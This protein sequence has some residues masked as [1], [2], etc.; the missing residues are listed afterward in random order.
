MW[1]I[2]GSV[3]VHGVA[4]LVGLHAAAAGPLPAGSAP[5]SAAQLAAENVLPIDVAPIVAAEPPAEPPLAGAE[6]TPLPVAPL[7]LARTS[8][9][10]SAPA[11]PAA[12]P[13][14]IATGPA[15]AASVAEAAPALTALAPEDGM[16]HFA[17]AIGGAAGQ[18]SGAVAQSGG[19]GG[20]PHAAGVAAIDAPLSEQGVSSPARLARGGAPPYPPSARADGIEGDVVLELVLSAAGSVE[21]ARVVKPA[22]HGLDDAALSAVRGYRFS[23]ASKDGH[24]VRVRMHWTMQFRLQ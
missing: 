2:A 5:H 20:A 9:P 16:P 13:A 7:P 10:P 4:L 1:A 12:G 22:G 17:I 11:R 6:A 21:S 8:V 14:S 3:G 24:A 23:P 15:G 19:P 18:P